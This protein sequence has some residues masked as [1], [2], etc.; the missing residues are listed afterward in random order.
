M[1]YSL[2]AFL[3]RFGLQ[4]AYLHAINGQDLP[5]FLLLDVVY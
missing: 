2:E 5:D 3:T 1:M 4:E